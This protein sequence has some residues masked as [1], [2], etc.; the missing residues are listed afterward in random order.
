M[1]ASSSAGVSKAP[2]T[3]ATL[4]SFHVIL[5]SPCLLLKPLNQDV[6]SCYFSALFSP[7]Q[8]SCTN[9]TART[10]ALHGQG[11]LN[12]ALLCHLPHH[13]YPFSGS[14]MLLDLQGRLLPPSL[15]CLRDTEV[16]TLHLS[17][18]AVPSCRRMRMG[19]GNRW[20]PSLCFRH[21]LGAWLSSAGPWSCVGQP[22]PTPLRQKA[23]RWA[24][25]Q[26][27]TQL[28]QP[29]GIKGSFNSP[30]SSSLPLPLFGVRVFHSSVT[31]LPFCSAGL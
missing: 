21:Y 22:L 13:N 2:A 18:R 9:P 20:S 30:F 12:A 17:P 16:G 28:S 23:R 27:D 3:R 1:V 19:L 15:Q 29:W 8:C 10:H 14:V 25:S 24:A 4:I 7:S 5:C 6:F 26:A 31:C 11:P